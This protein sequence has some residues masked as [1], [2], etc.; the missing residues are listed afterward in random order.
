MTPTPFRFESTLSPEDFQKIGQLSLR[1]SHIDHIIANCL[2]AL[3]GLSD[4]EAIVMVFP[5]STDARL[6][7]IKDLDQIKPIH[8]DGKRYFVE[9]DT[10]MRGIQAVRNNVIHAII[11]EG[12]PDGTVF[13]LRSKQRTW[14]KSEIFAAEELTNY[15]AHAALLLRHALGEKDPAGAPPPLPSRPEI[16]EFLRLLIKF[17]NG[18]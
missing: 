4:E 10:V 15:A 14:T 13:H 12:H 8:D 2:K 5:L 9:L 3:L 17:P 1:W 11:L 16:P 7:R 6:R 18:Q